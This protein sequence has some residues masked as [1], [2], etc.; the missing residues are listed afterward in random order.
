LA[1]V[2]DKKKPSK[3]KAKLLQ[4]QRRDAENAS[5]LLDAQPGELQLDVSLGI[6]V[7]P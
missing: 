7:K 1:A 6:F 4:E 5:P 3:K 2:S